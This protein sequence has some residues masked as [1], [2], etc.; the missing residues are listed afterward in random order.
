MTH[1]LEEYRYEI[2]FVCPGNFR[3][4]FDLWRRSASQSLTRSYEER[5]VNGVYF[6]SLDLNDFHDNVIGLAGRAKTRIRWYGETKGP[7]RTVLEHKLKH[8]R[9]CRKESTLLGD[10]DL[11]RMTWREL[12]EYLSAHTEPRSAVLANYFKNPVIRNRYRRQYFETRGHRVRMTVDRDLT[13]FDPV[14]TPMVLGGMKR[15]MSVDIIEFKAPVDRAAELEHLL[16]DFPLRVSRFSK[17]VT[18]V[19]SLRS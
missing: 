10:L 2:K 19:N 18:G 6:D 4:S 9:I 14:T 1:R 16:R 13:V 3:S 17:Y 8:G 11:P 7:V 15:G 12:A 5:I